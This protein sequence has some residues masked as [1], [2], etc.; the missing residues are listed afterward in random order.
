MWATLNF[1]FSEF[2]LDALAFLSVA[3]SSNKHVKLKRFACGKIYSAQ[4]N[5]SFRSLSSPADVS[6]TAREE[7][8]QLF[9]V[10]VVT[11][12]SLTFLL[13]LLLCSLRQIFRGHFGQGVCGW[14]HVQE[15]LVQLFL[16]QFLQLALQF[17]LV[18]IGS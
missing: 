4:A 13:F 10:Q 2:N 17:V 9:A 5:R 1:T 12:N 16:F 11:K 3:S 6:A 8:L 15:L 18:H 14:A 7:V